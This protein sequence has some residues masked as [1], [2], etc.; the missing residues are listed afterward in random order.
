MFY[1]THAEE[2][3]AKKEKSLSSELTME[4][5]LALP[6]EGVTVDYTGEANRIGD[7]V[8]MYAPINSCIKPFHREEIKILLNYTLEVMCCGSAKET[9]KTIADTILRNNP[10]PWYFFTLSCKLTIGAAEHEKS[11]VT[12]IYGF[13][14]YGAEEI[15]N[16]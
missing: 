4:V 12:C 6:L 10:L 2:M 9:A 16:E 15:H 7:V 11:I 14:P 3:R 8:I 1:L 13:E 5:Y